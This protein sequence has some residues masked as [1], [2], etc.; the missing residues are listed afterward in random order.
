MKVEGKNAVRELIKTETEI[1]KIL[2]VNG[3]KDPESKRLVSDIRAKGHKVQF[4]ESFVM[5]KESATGKHQGFIAFV[6][7]YAYADFQEIISDCE[8]KG[9]DALVVVLD[10]ILDPHNLGSIIRVCECSGVDG[11][12]IPERRSAQVNETVIRISEGGA[13]HVKIAR[14]TNVNTAL[15]ELQKNG[16]WVTGAELGG[17]DLYKADLTGKLC[18]VIGGEGTG[19]KKLTKE[20][21]DRIVTIPMKGKVNSLNASVACGVVVFEALRQRSGY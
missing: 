17:E 2:V 10:E 8:A 4:V 15:K 18:L 13:N 20:L 1:D 7:D 5:N 19:I 21:C 6:S 9:N 3:L 12:I 16:F 11:L 14:V